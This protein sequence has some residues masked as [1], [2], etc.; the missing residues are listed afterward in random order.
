MLNPIHSDEDSSI[1]PEERE[2]QRLTSIA[3]MEAEELEIPLKSILKKKPGEQEKDVI[4]VAFKVCALI[5]VLF[6]A[7]IVLS[8]L[9][10]A[11]AD[12]TCVNDTPKG[13]YLSL[14]NYLM[15][16]GFMGLWV[17][18]C[19]LVLIFVKE[20]TV[21]TIWCIRLVGLANALFCLT[22]NILGGIVFWGTVYPQGNCDL[23]LSTY[24]YI[25][26]I[27][28]IVANLYTISLK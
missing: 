9:Y 16:S 22:W 27:I 7:P 19:I 4:F 11:F 1:A 28:K 14:K 5:M 3:L 8:D 10:F 20:I 12:S 15:V 17:V 6:N 24:M 25:S 13:L 18:A 2:S 21:F 26:L 23:S